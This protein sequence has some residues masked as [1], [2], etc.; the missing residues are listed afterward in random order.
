MN[1]NI[2]L[3]DSMSA[4][5]ASSPRCEAQVAR[6]ESVGRDRDEGLGGEPLLLGERPARGLLAR[7]VAGRT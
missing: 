3:R 5:T 7:L 4:R 6:V 1:S 2:G